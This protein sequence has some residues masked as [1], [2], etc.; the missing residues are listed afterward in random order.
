MRKPVPEQEKYRVKDGP[1]AST[2]KD[3]NNGA[4]MFMGKM[5]LNILCLV[6][7][8]EGWEHVSVEIIPAPGMKQRLPHWDEMCYVA[9]IFWERH[10]V[11]LQY[12]PAEK[13][14]VNLNPYILHWWRPVSEKIP[15]PPK[16]M[17]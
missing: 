1:L 6:S 17:V 7:D 13:D 10:E 11:V 4:F 12:R 15:Q 8:T 3:G 16:W 9:N 5:G 14:Y 2:E